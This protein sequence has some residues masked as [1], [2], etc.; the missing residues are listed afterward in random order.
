MSDKVKHTKK[1]AKELLTDNN[2]KALI[3]AMQKSM[4]VITEAC[5]VANVSRSSFYLYYNS[6]PIFQKA[7]DE[8]E[9]IA[10]D[11]AE[12][13][14]YKQIKEGSTTATIFYLKTKGKQRGYVE[15]QQI[16]INKGQPDLSHL[17]S[18]DLIAL[19]NE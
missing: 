6:D 19:L 17:S 12:S 5:K 9:H 18:D 4:G 1:N 11:F 10:L 13:Q 3:D 8:C 7:C 15:R 2:K 16:D 14:L